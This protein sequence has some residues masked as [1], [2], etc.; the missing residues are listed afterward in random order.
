[1]VFRMVYRWMVGNTTVGF[2]TQTMQSIISKHFSRFVPETKNLT[3][4]QLDEVFSIPTSEHVMHGLYEASYF[5]RR[6]MLRQKGCIRPILIQIRDDN[7][8]VYAKEEDLQ[9]IGEEVEM[10]DRT[11]GRNRRRKTVR[12]G[13]VWGDEADRIER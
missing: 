9:P 7:Q 13:D 4:E 12:T 1:V 3:L 5:F 6:Y 8:S 11:D 10:M 2:Q